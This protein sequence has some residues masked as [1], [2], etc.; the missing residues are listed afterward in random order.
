[1][2]TEVVIVEVI[3]KADTEVEI[4]EVLLEINILHLLEIYLLNLLKT[5]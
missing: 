1:V 5:L 3:V 4:V 2:V